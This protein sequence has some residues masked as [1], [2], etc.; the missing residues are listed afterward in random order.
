MIDSEKKAV[1]LVSGGIDSAV[2]L[3]I[4]RSEGFHCIALSFDY[5]QRHRVELEY[6]KKIAADFASRHVII[7]IDFTKIGGSALT[8]EIPVPKSNE[9]RKDPAE[10][11][12]TYVPARNTI[13]LSFAL[14]LAETSNAESIFIGANA[15]D[16]SGYPDCRPGYISA[17]EIVANMGT[18]TAVQQKRRFTIRAP[19]IKLTKAEIILK[20]IQLGV[21]FRHTNSCYDPDPDGRACGSCDSCLIRKKGFLEAGIPDPTSYRT[22]GDPDG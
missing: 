12:I 8:D 18:K 17:F 19:L 9:Y 15:I 11:P 14:A 10:I 2:T 6:A 21:D 20:G 5:G 4:A 3:A 13:F 16:F 1:I 7:P 22:T